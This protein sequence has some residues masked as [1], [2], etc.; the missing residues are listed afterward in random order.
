MK[1]K[2]RITSN[3]SYGHDYDVET[4]SALKAASMYGRG[5]F[6]ETVTV[7]RPRSGKIVSRVMYTGIGGYSRRYVIP[8]ETIR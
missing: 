8:G 3:G 5:E 7:Y 2:C 6:G 4:S 1:Y